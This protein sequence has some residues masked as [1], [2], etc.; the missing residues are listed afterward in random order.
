M[1]KTKTNEIVYAFIDSQNLNLGVRSQ[2]WILDF[3]RFRVYLKEKYG[4]KKA[5]LFI[6]YVEGNQSLYTYLQKSDYICIFKP[7]LELN[8]NKKV[9]IKG[10]VDA[11][12]VLHSMIEYPNYDKAIVVSGDGDFHCLVEYLKE[13][14]KLLKIIVPNRKYSSL[15][16]EFSNYIVNI[17][18]MRSK[19]ELRKK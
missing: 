10:N 1:S 4:T 16:R 15:L 13:K 7:T 2:N 5:F 8:K 14:N 17:G 11:E 9:R 19:L 3:D 12:L 6:G 18:L